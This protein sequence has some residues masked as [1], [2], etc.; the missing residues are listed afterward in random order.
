[1]KNKYLISFI[2]PVYNA[3]RFIYTAIDSLLKQSGSDYQIILVDDGSLDNSGKIC[4]DLA[5]KHKNICSIHQPN[6]GSMAARIRGIKESSGEYI[7]FLDVD[8]IYY[9]DAIELFRNAILMH[10]ADII[11]FDYEQEKSEHQAI[12][13]IKA[14][15]SDETLIF[16]KENKKIVY[17]AFLD[18]RLNTM[19]ASLF[20]KKILQPEIQLHD[21]PKMK[22]G[23]D[24]LQK[25]RALEKAENIVYIPQVCYFYKWHS[26]SQFESTRK[27]KF[28]RSL[29][30]DFSIVWTVENSIY[31]K[32]NLSKKERI[33][34][35]ANKLMR[36][37]IIIESLLESSESKKREYIIKLKNDK[38]FMSLANKETMLYIRPY[39]KYLIIFAQKEKFVLLYCYYVVCKMLKYIKKSI[40]RK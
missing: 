6:G 23:E 7:A 27:N 34:Y 12:T 9:E 33:Q 32:I 17:R 11:L 22:V 13:R 40:I 2:I 4:D 25:Y 37:G 19:C 10:G 38:L 24:R 29:Y 20:R 15:D 18:G 31:E 1:M 36:I 39:Y 28:S 5:K 21:I 26:N 8:D 16:N 35:D 30:T 3:E 14:F